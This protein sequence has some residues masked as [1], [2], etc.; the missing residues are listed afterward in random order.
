MVEGMTLASVGDLFGVSRERV[1]Q[2]VRRAGV[3]VEQSAALRDKS[4]EW[5][6][7]DCGKTET[8]PPSRAE[9]VRCQDCD[10][11]RRRIGPDGQPSRGRGLDGH[12]WCRDP[13]TGKRMRFERYL[14]Q[15][16]LGRVLRSDEYV[17]L[18]DRDPDNVDPTNIVVTD[19]RTLALRRYGHIDSIPSTEAGEDGRTQ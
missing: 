17:T 4:V 3:T 7:L 9:C 5:S 8:R 12:W 16:Q 11:E 14:A 15:E 2:I 18:I 10:W 19:A 6:C 1:R 13:R